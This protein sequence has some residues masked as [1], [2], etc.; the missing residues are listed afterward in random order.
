MDWRDSVSFP[1]LFPKPG[2]ILVSSIEQALC[3]VS[4]STPCHIVSLY[5]IR[6]SVE[7][8]HDPPLY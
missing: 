2:D 8:Y 3:D 1:T 7:C 4:S 6:W 5:A